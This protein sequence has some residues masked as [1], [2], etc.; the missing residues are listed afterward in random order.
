MNYFLVLC[1]LIR[2]FALQKRSNSKT[3]FAV[4]RYKCYDY[5]KRTIR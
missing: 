3:E 4:E 5:S 2:T 1:S